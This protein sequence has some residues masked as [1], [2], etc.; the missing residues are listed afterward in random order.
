MP[1]PTKA[2]IAMA[3]AT[4]FALAVM[5]GVGEIPGQEMTATRPADQNSVS[6]KFAL[7]NPESR[8]ATA[9]FGNRDKRGARQGNPLWATPMSSLKATRERP[10]FSSSRRPPVVVNAAP[11][12][13]KP[14]AVAAPSRPRLLLVGAIA[15]ETESM[16][17]FIDETTKSV[18]QLK[19]GESHAGWELQSVSRQQ[20]LLLNEGQTVILALPSAPLK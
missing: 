3:C 1:P 12:P 13:S 17:I 20:V 5:A 11:V 15:G 16:A 7:G 4:G 9:K 19:T 18:V 10:L 14:L 6:S 2:L 8:G